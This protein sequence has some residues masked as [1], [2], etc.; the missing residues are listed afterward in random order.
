MA[1]QGLA[2]GY[3]QKQNYNKQSPQYHRCVL[4]PIREKGLYSLSFNK[5]LWARTL[6]QVGD[7]QVNKIWTLPL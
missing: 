3:C 7:G 2:A 1:F 4:S 6:S 5:H